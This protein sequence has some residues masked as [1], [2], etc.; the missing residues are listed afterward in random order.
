VLILQNF[1]VA[2]NYLTAD[3]V[4]GYFGRLTE[5]ALKKFQ[6]DQGLVCSGTPSTT[7]YGQTGPKTRAAIAKL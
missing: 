5:A 4:T 7:G 1:L 2:K 3:S 6:C